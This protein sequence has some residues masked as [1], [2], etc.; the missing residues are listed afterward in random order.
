MNC[1][2]TYMAVTLNLGQMKCPSNNITVKILLI[3]TLFFFSGCNIY[4][5]AYY[6]EPH[7][8][9]AKAYSQKPYDALIVTGFPH[10]KD[11]MTLIVQNRVRWAK[12]LFQTGIVKNVIFSGASVYTPYC[13]AEV[14]AKYAEQIGIP[15]ANIFIENKAEHS[16]EN[17]Y[18]SYLLAEEKGFKKIALGTEVTQSS[19][20]RS[21]NNQ[22]FKI[23]ADFIPIV[24]DSLYS[25]SKANPNFNE[26]SLEV[27]NFIS[28]LDRESL[29]KRLRGTRGRKVRKMIKQ[30]RKATVS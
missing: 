6:T 29:L 5:N 1:S 27:K 22:R 12:Y 15:K 18:F 8:Y 25:I 28:I 7:Q 23:K 4:Y 9:F 20:I 26:D 13:E 14:M 24:H 17:L 3:Y 2:K 30:K 19:F 11:S 10:H 21:L 16:I